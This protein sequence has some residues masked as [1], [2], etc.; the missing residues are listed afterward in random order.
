MQRA[1][2]ISCVRAVTSSQAVLGK[3]SK[4][5][6]HRAKPEGQSYHWSENM[7]HRRL[8]ATSFMESKETS[9]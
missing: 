4:M 9:C 1:C 5:V 7:G 6:K 2:F 8:R 3:T